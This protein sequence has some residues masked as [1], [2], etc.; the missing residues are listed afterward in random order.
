M[1]K[2]MGMIPDVLTLPQLAAYLQLPK[3]L[4]KRKV[5]DGS[6]SLKAC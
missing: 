1:G 6:S 5:E 3:D 4:V 2:E